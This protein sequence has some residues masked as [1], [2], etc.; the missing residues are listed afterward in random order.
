MAGLPYWTQD[1]GGFFVYDPLGEKNPEY[2][3]LFARWNQFGAFNPIYRI[4]GANIEREPYIF[5]TLAPEIYRSL[6]G[7]AQLRY[8][9]LP[10]V[11]SLAWQSTANAYTLMRG[12]PMDFPDDPRVRRT[13]DA[14]MFGPAFLVH[15]VTRAMYHKG[16]PPPDTIPTEALETPDG[17]PGLAVQYFEGLDFD[18]PAGSAIDGRVEHSWPGPP[19]ADPPAGLTGFDNFSARWEGVLTAP[20]DGEYEFGVEYDDGARLFLDGKQLVEDWSFGAKRYRGAKITLAKGQRLPVK[21]EFHQGGQE[22]FF[23]LGWRTPSERR[24]LAA[25]AAEFD[26]TVETYLPAGADWYDFWTGERFSGGRTVKKHCPLDVSRCTCAPARSCP[27]APP[28]STRP[29]APRPPTRSA[30]IPGRTHA[31]RSTRT[32]TRPT[33]TRRGER[34]T[35]DL[36]WDDAA[37]T[38]HIG[39]RQGSFPGLVAQRKLTA[40]LMTPGGGA[41]AP[42][43]Q[44]TVESVVYTGEPVVLKLTH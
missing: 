20:E 6:L 1:T 30:S 25:Q 40:L 16:D 14:F 36:V 5:K 7:A 3:E 24:A 15:P 38:L 31:S 21:A 13:D 34:A 22:R 44:R 29:S 23:R 19:L 9:L 11:Y 35:Y 42:A 12:L 32:T 27:W 4:H 2:Q 17:Q 41:A 39:A 18:R 28:C 10:Y 43:A 37:Q 26:N 8:E 33:P